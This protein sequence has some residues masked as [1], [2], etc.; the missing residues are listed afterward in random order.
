M[1]SN[2]PFSID[3]PWSRSVSDVAEA[4]HSDIEGGLNQSEAEARLE[5]CGPNRLA[6]ST[7]RS[8][9]RVFLGQFADLMI[10]LLV[11]AAVISGLI[12]EWA[13]TALIGL[14]VLANAVIG[15]VQEWRA[16][17]A[18][19]AL[20]SLTQPQAR[21]RRGGTIHDV[22]AE[23]V[24][25]GDV[26]ELSAGDFVPADA[27]V[28]EESELE[29]DEAALTGESLPV[30]K[31][32]NLVEAGVPLPDRVCMV[33]SGTA[34]VGGTGRAI[35]TATGMSTELGN[36]AELLTTAEDVQTPLQQR[37]SVLSRRLA[38]IV[39]GVCILIFA[40]GVLRED[41][42]AWDRSL[43]TTMLLTAVSLAVAAI[44]E[45]L[46]AVITV[47]LALGSQRM[48]KR[49]AI[50]RRLSAVETL[51]S[52][53]VICTDKT[54][55]L[56]QNRM[57][58]ADVVPAG[59]SDDA[60]QQLLTAVALCNDA[61][62]DSKGE[63]SGSA[64]ES[65]LYQAV[66]DAG[67]DA[68]AIRAD[69]PR[70][71]EIPFSSERKRMSTLHAEPDG[72][73]RLY[74]KGAVERILQLCNNDDPQFH[75]R[76]EELAGQGR[77]VLAFADRDF[78]GNSL[79][80]D[81]VETGLRFLGVVGI[82]DPPRPEAKEAIARCR[83]A[84][85]RP[86]MI[87]GDHPGT[88][89][90]IASELELWQPG[91]D[92]VSGTE[93]DAMSE[94]DLSQKSKTASV[95]ARVSPEHKLKI[96]RAHQ[97]HGSVTSMTGDGV[98]DAPA[99]KQADIGVAMGITG[100]DVAKE[101]AEMVLAD[102]NFA[103]IVA[104]VE[105]GRVVYDN[106]RKFVAYML[107]ANAGEVLV[108]FLGIVWGLPIPLLPVHILW[109]NLVTDGLPALALGFEPA[110]PD[111]MKRAP[112]PREESLFG[113]GLGW[114]ILS[115]GSLM[116]IFCFAAYWWCEPTNTPEGAEN[117]ERS[118]TIL[119]VALSLSQ[120]FYVLAVRSSSELFFEAGLWSNYRLTGA[121]VIGIVL[122]MAVVYVPFMQPFFHTTGLDASDLCPTM[123]AL[124]HLLLGQLNE[125]S[126]LQI[127]AAV[128]ECRQ[129]AARCQEL[130]VRQDVKAAL[131]DDWAKRCT[132][133]DP[134]QLLAE[135]S[136]HRDESQAAEQGGMT[137][138]Q[139]TVTFPNSR[140]RAARS[141]KESTT[142]FPRDFG[143]YELIEEIAS[144]GMGVVYRAR[145]KNLNRIVALKMIRTGRFA[146]SDEVRRFHVEAEAA[147]ALDHPHIVPV[148]EVG[149][150]A[151][152]HFFSM[153]YV[154]G[155]S[156]AD[157]LANGPL[158]VSDAAELLQTVSKA[159]QYAHDNGIV[160]R[161][162]KPGNILLQDG[163]RPAENGSTAWDVDETYPSSSANRPSTERGETSGR[164]TPRITDFG[165]AKQTG[166][167][168][169][170]TATGQV[171][172]TPSY[173]PPEQA[174]GDLAAV[175][176]HSD[177]YSLGAVL[178]ATLTGRPPFQA[179]SPVLTLE[180]VLSREPVSPRVLNP[181]VDVDLETICLKA[182]QKETEQRYASAAEL[183]DDLQRF[184]ENRPILARPI[185][186]HER[187]R[188]WC[189]R[190]P[191]VAI[192]SA[193]TLVALIVGTTVSSVF[194]IRASAALEVA[195][196][197]TER[198]NDEKDRAD[199]NARQITKAFEIVKQQ[200]DKAQAALASEKIAL[201]QTRE[202]IDAYV[203]TVQRAELLN[204]PRFQPLLKLLL[205]DALAHYTRF[206]DTHQHDPESQSQ[207]ATAVET[208]ALIHVHSG[209]RQEG[210]KAYRKAL[211]LYREL[212]R[213]TPESAT[214]QNSLT[215]VEANI[216]W[217]AYRTKGAASATFA[218]YRSALE[219]AKE[220]VK[221]A[222]QD[223]TIVG[224]LSETY[225]KIA[226]LQ[227]KTGQQKLAIASFQN[228][229]DHQKSIA[230]ST[231][232]TLSKL[233][234]YLANQGLTW[235]DLQRVDQA[236][237]LFHQ[238]LEIRERLYKQFPNDRNHCAG[239]I[240][241]RT[242][243]ST[244]LAAKGDHKQARE[245]LLSGVQLCEQLVS[246]HPNHNDYRNQLA[247]L[248]QELG[249][250][251]TAADGPQAALNYYEKARS[252]WNALSTQNPTMHEYRSSLAGTIRS[253]GNIYEFR[254]NLPAA[255][256]EY[257]KAKSITE[258]LIEEVPSIPN[259]RDQS[260]TDSVVLANVY[261]RMKKHVEAVREYQR[262]IAMQTPLVEDHPDVL[263][264]RQKLARFNE[265]FGFYFSGIG[266]PASAAN[267]QRNALKLHQDLYRR[268]PNNSQRAVDLGGNHIN[269]AKSLAN[270]GQQL[271][272]LSH[273][274]K[275]I[276]L[277]EGV[278]KTNPADANAGPFLN[279][280]HW[281]RA[282]SF[283]ALKRF[284]KAADDWN[285]AGRYAPAANRRFFASH[286]AR[287]LALDG[288]HAQAARVAKETVKTATGDGRTLLTLAG[289]FGLAARAAGND[290]NVPA[291]DRDK[292]AARHFAE[293]A[294][295]FELTEA[296]GYLK[297][298]HAQ[299]RLRQS[300]TFA[301]LRNHKDFRR[302]F[303]DVV[304]PKK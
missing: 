67:H 201:Q 15:F 80:S 57:E 197:E 287:C 241:I 185:S 95:Y 78:D 290:T 106:I 88:A 296:T 133:N 99:L 151:E 283:E 226:V 211:E 103:T 96:V 75:Q 183:A 11:A 172:G 130:T 275:G 288:K 279:T 145:Q 284:A 260:A 164:L 45:G 299:A 63:V 46:P 301:A 255:I 28:V 97:S 43:L 60:E 200:R 74:V 149:E 53:N 90:A 182:M 1:T 72:S 54:G 232:A 9:L 79:S 120:L 270:T 31:S 244:L 23:D 184:L 208:V 16:E 82:V 122:Q 32:I 193:L 26:V 147:A 113:D 89:K 8:P 292:I 176:S 216:G 92:I 269:L 38:L 48:T 245:S 267:Y 246:K 98:N 165:L 141:P 138:D 14:I 273:F 159:V 171:M 195:N 223:I 202:T 152:Q 143:E 156:L 121:V 25:P 277:L 70:V 238:A 91:D 196:E 36:I 85:I 236:E 65:A 221:N 10:G 3:Q 174:R 139:P 101:S 258:K 274:E 210:L 272:A 278:I 190:N 107:T 303:A 51:G 68:T 83:S 229:I 181:A 47:T 271:K 110:E 203:K 254:G 41:S 264:Y 265:Q 204:E 189:A 56:T 179:A 40:A 253:L 136:R 289:V 37:L 71:D 224:E 137:V 62:I 33:Y 212:A 268:T 55:T 192:F 213:K 168:S 150:Y 205:R 222:P 169:D 34:V 116:A 142:S 118:R 30:E 93:L 218:L 231:T 180:Q 4:L 167:E 17:Q 188:R 119:F 129:C 154:E 163:R 134:K 13:D 291:A 125:E 295:M 219:R 294:R 124:L 42:S 199:A 64:T 263:R 233:S 87:T 108:L 111:I 298:P 94:D 228:A 50:V 237:P 27:R 162:L 194:A 109:I 2:S 207:L 157:V 266:D 160:H 286:Q 35:V 259:Y 81:E 302:Y 100:T 170:L 297:T 58:V 69:H 282:N 285:S 20:K 191:A 230:E 115:I 6:E 112:R 135:L 140:Q 186:W 76:A 126:T 24:V 248:Y 104:A 131:G 177:V 77:R 86:V 5:T 73:H 158:P 66:I 227:R 250:S 102:D 217:L 29:I 173:M 117:L 215:R 247:Q 155:S 18:V 44:P 262:G 251:Q 52:V 225:N 234:E 161:D 49:H 235:L 127:S 281:S 256:S 12:G 242:N 146:D 220:R 206:I 240:S 144:G 19:A 239:L 153:G 304:K 128:S 187:A 148:F 249:N 21:V 61:E 105:E 22:A 59:E 178:Y 166:A 209:D 123:A 7:S 198:A 214:I 280:A 300:S 252:I 175:G 114:R 243:L 276:G 132:V 293:A 261:A 39:I 84:G 257:V